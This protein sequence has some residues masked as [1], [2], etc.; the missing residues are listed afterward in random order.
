MTTRSVLR[1]SAK[2][3]ATSACS[4]AVARAVAAASA[5]ISRARASAS[6]KPVVCAIDVGVIERKRVGEMREQAA[7]QRG[8]HAGRDRQ[9]QV[10]VF[11]GRGAPRIDDDQ[12]GAALAFRGNHPL[13]ED[14]M[15]PR[16]VRADQHDEVGFVD[17]PVDAGHGV[18]A[19]SAAMAGNRGGHAQARIGVDIG[20]A[21]EAL[22]Q[23]VGDVIVLGEQLPGEIERDRA[24]AVAI[25]DRAQSARNLVER[26]CPNRR[27]ASEPSA[28]RSIG[29]SRRRSSDSVSPSAEP[30]EHS[31]PKFAGCAGSPEIA[32]AAFAVRCRKHPAADAAIR[33]RGAHGGR[34]RGTAFMP[35]SGRS[36]DRLADI[37]IT[38]P[39]ARPA[40]DRRRDPRGRIRSRRRSE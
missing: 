3:R 26:A 21:E 12:F 38:P 37:G 25:D 23:L 24:R 31:R 14:R 33:A 27:A 10:G 11:G 30:F 22:H 32:R 40:L 8:I 5:A 28:C 39:A 4:S 9:E 19:E 17:V 7:E 35:A 16:R 18:G 1:N 34:M 15:T 13:I 6:T 20:R 36:V 2:K 29:C